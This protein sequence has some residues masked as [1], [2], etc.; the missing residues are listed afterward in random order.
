[1][2][3]SRSQRRHRLALLF[4]GLFVFAVFTQLGVGWYQRR[5]TVRS[6]LRKAVDEV[7]R[8]LRYSDRWDLQRYKQADLGGSYYILDRSGLIIDTHGYVAGLDFRADPTDLQPNIGSLWVPLTNETWRL[9]V[10]PLMGGVVTGL[11]DVATFITF[12]S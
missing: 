1:M 3:F 8:E 11:W 7:R 6:D 5:A 2:T 4:A 12:L 10:A 9:L